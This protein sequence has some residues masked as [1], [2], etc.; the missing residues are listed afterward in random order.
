[1]ADAEDTTRNAMKF[2]IDPIIKI[3]SDE[4]N[5]QLVSESDY[6]KGERIQIKRISYRDIFDIAVAI[7]KL[8]SSGAFNGDEIRDETG[9]E[10]T[11]EEIHKKYFI[12]KNYQESGQALEGGDKE[13]D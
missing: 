10:L 3:I 9:F 8:I 6:L 12:T 1:I 5:M 11:D 13:V 2:C 4:L 7:D